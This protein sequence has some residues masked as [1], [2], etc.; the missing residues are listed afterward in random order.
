MTKENDETS[1]QEKTKSRR[2]RDGPFQQQKLPAW[3][4]VMIPK[5]VLPTLFIIGIIFCPA[6]GLLWWSS[7]RVDEIMINYSYCRQYPNPVY[8]VPE[9]YDYQLSNKTV[10]LTEIEPPAYHYSNESTFL[11]PNWGNPNQLTVSRCTLDF[12]VPTTMKG[13]VYMYYRLTNFYQ[14]HRQYIKNFD[15]SQLLGDVVSSTT[16]HTDCDPLAYSNGK[17]IY[18]CGLIANSMFNDTVSNFTSID[19]P[20][21]TYSFSSNNIAWPS[22]KKKY[23]PTKYPLSDIVPPPNWANRYPNGQYTTEYPPPNLSQDEHFMVWMHVAALPDFRKIWGRNDSSD[24]PAGRWRVTIDMNFD[25]LQYSGTKW[26]VLSTTTPL[27]GR[28][29]YLGIAYMAIGAICILLGIV[30]SLRHLIKPRKLGDESY[31]SWNQPGGGLP[32]NKRANELEHLHKE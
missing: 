24:L 22:D 10:N 28:N 30:F 23:G 32:K 27:G 20:S 9:L 19:H 1:E 3:Q 7:N 17:V 12:T 14:N 6:G 4:P 11:N 18:P 16:L 13:P 21:L 15:S 26:L 2:P 29:P 8:L 25:T 31:L 5:T